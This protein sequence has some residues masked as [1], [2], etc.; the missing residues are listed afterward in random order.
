LARP[1]L[2][3]RIVAL[4]WNHGHFVKSLP[5]GGGK[6]DPNAKEVDKPA[7]PFAEST[8]ASIVKKA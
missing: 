4:I 1:F 8:E 7:R 2:G 6:V 3:G 5:D